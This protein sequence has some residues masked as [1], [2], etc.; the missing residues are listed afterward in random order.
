MTRKRSKPKFLNHWL[1]MLIWL[2]IMLYF[3]SAPDPYAV[4]DDVEPPALMDTLGHIFG[5]FVLGLFATRIATRMAGRTPRAM[6]WVLCLGILYGQLD[7]MHQM[8]IPGRA[9]SSWDVLCDS[10]GVALAIS[11]RLIHWRIW[12]ANRKTSE[13]L[14][15]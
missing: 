5:Y 10:L 11:L 13:N 3:T 12:R 4:L 7:E 9:Y 14:K 2:G 8:P 1:P 15:L 6:L